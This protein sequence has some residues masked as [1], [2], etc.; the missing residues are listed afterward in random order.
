MAAAYVA[1][2]VGWVLLVVGVSARART[3][4]CA[5]VTL[6]ALLV[7]GTI[8]GPRLDGDVAASIHPVPSHFAFR[9]ALEADIGPHSAERGGGRNRLRASCTLPRAGGK[10]S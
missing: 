6:M 5:L 10:P 9:S 3:G 1:Y 7:R 8:L 4:R 2:L